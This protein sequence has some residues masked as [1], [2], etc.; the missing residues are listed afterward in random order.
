MTKDLL[1]VVSAVGCLLVGATARAGETSTVQRA[2]SGLAALGLK[3]G[4]V[5]GIAGPLTRA[6]ISRFQQVSGLR[7]SGDLD[8]KTRAKLDEVITSASSAPEDTASHPLERT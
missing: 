5:D 2:Q 8:A 6:A 3:P 7:A 4:P 1:R